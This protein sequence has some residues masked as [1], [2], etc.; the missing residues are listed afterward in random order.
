MRGDRTFSLSSPSRDH[1]RRLHRWGLVP[2][3]G[4]LVAEDRCHLL[5][6]ELV[7]E[8]GHGRSIGDA[9]D[10]LARQSTQHG[11]DMLGRIARGHDRAAFERGEHSREPLPGELMAGRAL[12]AVHLLA[13]RGPRRL[14]G[15]DLPGA[16]D[17]WLGVI[18]AAK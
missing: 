17:A 14:A 3:A 16:D 4:A 1:V 12:V 9:A 11:A 10:G 7:G 8:R 2:P 18:T 15:P 6:A 5:V 13:E